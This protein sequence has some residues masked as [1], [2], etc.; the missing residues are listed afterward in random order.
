[1]PQP[2]H[3]KAKPTIAEHSSYRPLNAGRYRVALSHDGYQPA[4]S[5]PIS[6]NRAMVAVTL[7]MQRA[8]S[9]LRVIAVTTARASQALQQASTFSKTLDTEQLQKEGIVRLG[10]ALRTLPGVNNGITGDTA[11]LADDVQLNIRGIGTLETQAAID[12]HPI[13]YGVKGGFN[14]QLSPAFPYRNVSVLYGSGG[15]DLTGVNAIG[16]VVNF[17]TLDPTPRAAVSVQQGY[18]TFAQLATTIT[19]TGTSNRL[20]YAVAYGVA[21]LDGPFR[22]ATFYQPGAAFD[23]SV[24]SGPVHDLGVYTDDSAAITR[25]GLLKLQ[26]D[27]A[28]QSRLMLTS[29][30]E[31]RWMNKTGNGDGDYLA[32]APALAFGQHLLGQYKPANYPNLPACPAGTFVGTNVNGAPNGYGPGG[33]PDGG[34]TCQTPQQYAAF[35]T[36]WDG[37]GPSWQSLKLIDNTLAYQYSGAHAIVRAS[38]FNSSYANIVDRRF[39]LPFKSA[40]GDAGSVQSFGVNE[41]G[42]NLSDDL[43]GRAND[44]EVGASYLNNAYFAY[45]DDALK[46]APFATETALFLRDA[47]HPETSRVTAFANLWAKHSTATNTSY[48][49]SRFA[50]MY[51]LTPHDDLRASAG[52]TT[53][54]PSQNMLN[55]Q[56]VGSFTGG[57]GGGTPVSCSALN[58]IGNAPST[59]LKPERGVDEDL[60]YVHRWQADTQMQVTVYTTNVYD[61]LYSTLLPL[62]VTGT[63]FIPASYLVQVEATIAGKCGAG[64]VPALLG[65]TGN[66]NVGALRARGADISGRIRANS[67]LFFDYDWALT[68]TALVSAN[69]QLLQHNLTYIIGSQSAAPSAAYVYRRRRLHVPQRYYGTIFTVCGFRK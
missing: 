44:V 17:H 9:S 49:D 12:G 7:V 15:A 58:A 61:K 46:G 54:Q 57:A 59:L 21:G 40:P 43:L 24:T 47:Y 1:M 14:Y 29:V 31:N 69:P 8:A 5:E 2:A 28:P 64:A 10:D 62:S 67:R 45:T 20:G 25:A 37:A 48:L 32:Y 60:A 30:A 16:G 42:G 6:V 4:V 34:V 11:A 52:S 3:L 53:T 13:A 56:F 41:T 63:N 27:L 33:S 39:M 68:S 18:G 19:A 65:V 26:Y 38:A 66:V 36:G 50:V 35:N 55:Q 51:R 23:Q 22:N